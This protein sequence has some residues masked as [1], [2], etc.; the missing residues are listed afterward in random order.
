MGPIQEYARMAE[1]FS[2][3]P[4]HSRLFSWAEFMAEESA[5][6]KGRSRKP[7]PASPS[8]FEWALDLEKEREGE[9]VGAGR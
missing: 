6:P 7:Q 2:P 1:V 5:K 4:P 3:P 8:L 9:T